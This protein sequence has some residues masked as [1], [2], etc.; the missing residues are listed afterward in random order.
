MTT[1]QGDLAYSEPARTDIV[2][3]KYEGE[4]A[5]RIGKVEIRTGKKFL[6][7]GEACVATF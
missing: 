4:W 2:T 6:A 5:F 1:E 7:V 3:K